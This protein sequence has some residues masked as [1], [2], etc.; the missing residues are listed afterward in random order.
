[1]KQL[2]ARTTQPQQAGGTGT[3]HWARQLIMTTTCSKSVGISSGGRSQANKVRKPLMYSP[4]LGCLA[5]A[6]DRSL[7]CKPQGGSG[8]VHGLR[9]RRHRLHC[10]AKAKGRS[11]TLQCQHLWCR[12]GASTSHLMDAPPSTLVNTVL[13]MPATCSRS[14][15]WLQCMFPTLD[16]H[17][18]NM[19]PRTSADW[20]A[21]S[22]SIL[23]GL[24][25]SHMRVH[26]ES[27]CNAFSKRWSDSHRDHE[28]GLNDQLHRSSE[29]STFSVQQSRQ[30]WR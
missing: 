8:A 3:G 18:G 11:D 30:G 4:A 19:C 7:R 5:C 12:S 23:H 6:L 1:M 9:H 10:T 2:P 29:H 24:I 25:A 22:S 20:P 16:E 26:C 13:Q 15:A 21:R 14:Q 28:V 27:A 17:H